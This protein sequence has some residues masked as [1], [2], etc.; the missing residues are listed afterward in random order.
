MKAWIT[1]LVFFI[2]VADAGIVLVAG[3]VM[4]GLFV[5]GYDAKRMFDERVWPA[6]VTL[7]LTTLAA[8][9]ILWTA[10]WLSA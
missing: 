7:V 4:S 9:A 5:A 10:G 1:D 6:M 2:G 8:A 3:L